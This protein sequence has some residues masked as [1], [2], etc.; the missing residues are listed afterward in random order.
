MEA[1]EGR[2]IE[3]VSVKLPFQVKDKVTCRIISMPS[4]QP[5]VNRVLILDGSYP[6]ER[7][8]GLIHEDFYQYYGL[9]IGDQLRLEI[10]GKEHDVAI[11]GSMRTTEYLYPMKDQMDMTPSTRNFAILYVPQEQVQDL[12]G[13]GSNFNDI[14]VRFQPGTDEEALTEQIEHMLEPYGLLKTI[15]REYQPSAMTIEME[16]MGLEQMAVMFPFLFLSVAGFTIYILLFRLVNQQKQQIGLFM[17]LG[18]PARSIFLYYRAL[19]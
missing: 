12:L 2:I 4:P 19:L 7:Y 11:S 15:P 6:R 13:F 16:M 5:D 8:S 14:S 18:V 1:A 17:A 10:Q 9:N 3:D